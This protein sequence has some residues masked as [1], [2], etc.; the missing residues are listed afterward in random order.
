MS[1]LKLT[2]NGF[3][4]RI[5]GC[6]ATE[7]PTVPQPLIAFS[8]VLFFFYFY[9]SFSVSL[10]ATV[11]LYVRLASFCL[12]MSP[13]SLPIRFFTNPLISISL[14]FYFFFFF[15]NEPPFHF[16]QKFP[17]VTFLYVK[18]ISSSSSAR[19]KPILLFLFLTISPNNSNTYCKRK[20]KWDAYQNWR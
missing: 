8:I 10:F 16:W 14:F 19:A 4:L 7:L 13:Y 12:S 1:P 18:L 15:F 5:S 3:K 11:P 6:E 2:M 20:A 17:T 9:L